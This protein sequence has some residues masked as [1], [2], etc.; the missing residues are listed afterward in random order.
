MSWP[1]SYTH[2]DVYKRQVVSTDETYIPERVNELY[3]AA[4]Y[5]AHFEAD[6]VTPPA[7]T[8]TPDEPTETTPTGTT[9]TVT[10]P[11][12]A[13]AVLGEAF[14][15]VQPEVGVLGLSLIHI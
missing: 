7:P 14:A 9:P 2:L 13:T 5:T 15:P 1:V 6:V 12:E 11:T 10:A 3:A 4:T 8:P